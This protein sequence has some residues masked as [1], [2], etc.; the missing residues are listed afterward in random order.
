MIINNNNL[1]IG[2]ISDTH[3]HLD[4]RI[5]KL[6][7]ECDYAIHAG[8]ICGQGILNAMRPKTGKVFVVAG[9]ND[10]YC[11]DS[12]PLP[13]E[14]TLELPN[15]KI[16]VEHGHEHGMIQPSHQSLRKKY[17]N[18]R[19]VIYGHTHKQLVD[20]DALPWIINPGAAGLTRNHGGPSCLVLH[21]DHNDWQIEMI[22]FEN[23]EK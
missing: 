4:E 6:I 8:D 3:A 18:S 20:K 11:H 12:E 22:R 23:I 16:S 21:C 15:G 2:I 17:V 14:L 19:I 7:K 5:I 13:D 1:S 10:H 9:N